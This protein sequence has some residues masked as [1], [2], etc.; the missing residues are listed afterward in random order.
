MWKEHNRQV[1]GGL[2][3]A[4]EDKTLNSRS[5]FGP[6]HGQIL[7]VFGRDAGLLILPRQIQIQANGRTR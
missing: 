4:H 6:R 5:V 7:T 1:P 3:K 2:D